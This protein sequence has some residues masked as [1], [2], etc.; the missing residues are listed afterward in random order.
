MKTYL[1]ANMAATRTFITVQNSKFNFDIGAR[2][3]GGWSQPRFLNF[4]LQSAKVSKRQ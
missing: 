1:F 2:R 4:T 3:L